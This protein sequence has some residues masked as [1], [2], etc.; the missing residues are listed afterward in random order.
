[1]TALA[2][3]RLPLV[4]VFYE[5]EVVPEWTVRVN[6][7]TRVLCE[8]P[9]RRQG[10]KVRTGGLNAA[11]FPPPEDVAFA[12]AAC[13]DARV[14]LKFTAGLHHPVRHFNAGV[15]TKMHGFLNVFG[16]GVLAHARGLS[17]DQIVE[18]IA[19][20]DARNFA[21]DDAGFRWKDWRASVE[22]IAAA[23]RELVTSFGSCS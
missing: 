22:E 4:T 8:D 18:I 10:L 1:D 21:F 5:I 13:R 16:A 19:D 3:Q 9:L 2:G 7:L 12:V 23:R 15:Q 11:A 6:T 20:Q 14:P 17:E